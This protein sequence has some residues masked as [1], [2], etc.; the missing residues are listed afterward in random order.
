M[1]RQEYRLWSCE[2]RTGDGQAKG[3]RNIMY[4]RTDF[5][6]PSRREVQMIRL[7]WWLNIRY[8]AVGNEEM[9]HTLHAKGYWQSIFHLNNAMEEFGWQKNNE[10]IENCDISAQRFRH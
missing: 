5:E 8:H 9:G 7:I 2:H 10:W 3:G 6:A 1:T 4:D